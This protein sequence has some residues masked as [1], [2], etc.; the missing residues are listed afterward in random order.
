[1][2][3]TLLPWLLL[4]TMFQVTKSKFTPATQNCT[5]D[6][7][8]VNLR[9]DNL[10]DPTFYDELFDRHTDQGLGRE[11]TGLTGASPIICAGDW[12]VVLSGSQ[13]WPCKNPMGDHLLLRLS[14]NKVDLSDKRLRSFIQQRLVAPEDGLLL[15]Q[16]LSCSGRDGG[17]PGGQVDLLG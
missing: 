6:A 10:L 4:P 13:S 3:W 8:S 15:G 7:H 17:P 16:D 9:H 12:D 5:K 1:M 11:V 14:K 2:V